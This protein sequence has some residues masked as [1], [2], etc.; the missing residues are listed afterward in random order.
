MPVL[1]ENGPED[2]AVAVVIGKLRILQLRIELRDFFHEI[3]ITP[4]AASRGCLGILADRGDK[5]FIRGISLLLRI[6][7]L[8]VAFL[9]PPGVADIGI[10]KEI[11]LMH[12]A[13]HAL[14]GW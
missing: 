12:V 9:V 4:K 2:P 1:F 7:E 11:A 14:T 10:N 5:F 3:E 8:A 13:N 6:H